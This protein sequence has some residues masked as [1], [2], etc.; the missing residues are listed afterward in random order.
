MKMITP[1]KAIA[2]A[3]LP[4]SIESAPSVGPTVRSSTTVRGTGNAAG[5]Q[6]QRELLRFGHRE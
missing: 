6:Q 4:A 2:E 5:P 1:A 3:I